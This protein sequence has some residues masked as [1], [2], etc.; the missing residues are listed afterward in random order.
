MA[1]KKGAHVPHHSE[2]RRPSSDDW[3]P[4]AEDGTVQV[5]FLELST[6]QWRVCVWGDDDCGMDRDFA[7]DEREA[8][9]RLYDLLAG[10]SDVTKRLCLDLGMVSA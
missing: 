5:S 7:P 8:A 4:T 2:T 3:H 10:C 6:G 9:S 1:M